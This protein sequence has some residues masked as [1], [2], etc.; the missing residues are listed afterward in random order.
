MSMEPNWED[1]GCELAPSCLNCPLVVCKYDSPHH[2]RLENRD[3]QIRDRRSAGVPISEIELEFGVSQR[4]VYRALETRARRGTLASGRPGSISLRQ[5][6]EI[7][8]AEIY[9]KG[10]S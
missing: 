6:N 3:E 8:R 7:R 5:W 1:R 9:F 10:I 2:Y 4:T